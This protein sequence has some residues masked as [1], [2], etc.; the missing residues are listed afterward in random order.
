MPKGVGAQLPLSVLCGYDV[1]E[2]M[3]FLK[4]LDQDDRVSA[5]LTTRTIL[6]IRK[7]NILKLLATGVFFI[8]VMRNN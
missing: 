6:I 4:S 1:I 3:R 8:L 7:L 5:S 2:A